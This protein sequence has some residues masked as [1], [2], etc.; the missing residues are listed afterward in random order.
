MHD[1][2]MDASRRKMIP[3]V[4]T[5]LDARIYPAC[6]RSGS[7]DRDPLLL[8]S[9]DHRP[10]RPCRTSG[11]EAAALAG[12]PSLFTSHSVATLGACCTSGSCILLVAAQQDPGDT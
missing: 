8:A 2:S 4:S 1:L 6:C 5:A 3:L 12:E 10:R 11:L 7:R 9:Q